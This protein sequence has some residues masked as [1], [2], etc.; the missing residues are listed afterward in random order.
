MVKNQIEKIRGP[1]PY[2]HLFKT[3]NDLSVTEEILI[4][5]GHLTFGKLAHLFKFES[6]IYDHSTN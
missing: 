4:D 6:P 1:S 5:S 3:E 2:L